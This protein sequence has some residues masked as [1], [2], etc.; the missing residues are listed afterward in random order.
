MLRLDIIETADGVDVRTSDFSSEKK[1]AID[2]ESRRAREDTRGREGDQ[3]PYDCALAIV[4]KCSRS[5]LLWLFVF[6]PLSLMLKKNDSC[7]EHILFLY[8]ILKTIFH[9][10]SPNVS[11]SDFERTA[12]ATPADLIRVT[13][14]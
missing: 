14:T 11:S 10:K 1:A 13:T 9:Y 2:E 6:P 7:S 3:C 5:L 12:H 8:A 4:C